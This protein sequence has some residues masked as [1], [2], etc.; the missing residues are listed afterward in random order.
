VFPTINMAKAHARF[1]RK[2]ILDNPVLFHPRNTE[3]FNECGIHI[4]AGFPNDMGWYC[5]GHNSYHEIHR[6]VWAV[7]NRR[8]SDDFISAFSG[9]VHDVEHGACEEREY[10]HQGRAYGWD[11]SAHSTPCLPPG[12]SMWRLNSPDGGDTMECRMFSANVDLLL[13]A[14]D[15]THSM[16]NFAKHWLS[17]GNEGEYPYLYDW[18]EWLDK[19]RTAKYPDL[20]QAAP[21]HLIS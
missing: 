10:V 20:R 21:F 12:F 7:C 1:I 4:H 6:V 13:P 3:V 9:R 11:R 16:V 2:V 17:K 15:F 18:A 8:T 5:N 19:Q 14:I